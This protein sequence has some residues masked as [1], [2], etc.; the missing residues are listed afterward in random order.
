MVMID[1]PRPGTGALVL[2]AVA[3]LVLASACSRLGEPGAGERVDGVP[4]SEATEPTTVTVPV[5]TDGPRPSPPL[6][7]PLLQSP[8]LQFSEFGPAEPWFPGP[9]SAIHDI[10]DNTPK[11]ADS[12]SSV[13]PGGSKEPTKE[14]VLKD[15]R[16]RDAIL[17][18]FEPSFVS[19]TE[20][21][22]LMASSELVLGLSV[23]AESHAYSIPYLSGREVVNDVVGGKPVALTW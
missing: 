13:P 5:G 18:V 10:I 3:V 6:R 22:E 19:A 14:L 1:Q 15:V 2:L 8:P 16:K 20:A 7:S 11:T 4:S 12:Q 23:G 17:A 21:D 9:V